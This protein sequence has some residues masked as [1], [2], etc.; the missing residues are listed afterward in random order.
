MST[1]TETSTR[2]MCQGHAVGLAESLAELWAAVDSGAEYEG[3]DPIEYLDEWPL[4]IVWERGEP[5]AV[6]FGTGGPHVELRGGSRHDG[7]GYAVHV[8]WSGEHVVYRGSQD[9]LER[10][11]EY[12]RELVED[13]DS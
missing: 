2:D 4:E 6:V 3:S 9:A 10:T 11:G 5:F 13:S 7:A 12:F 1:M 8:Y